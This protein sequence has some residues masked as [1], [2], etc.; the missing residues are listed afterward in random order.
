MANALTE[1]QKKLYAQK[2]DRYES[3]FGRIV[4]S[5]LKGGSLSTMK[6]AFELELR[7]YYTQLALLAKGGR[8][9]TLQDKIDLGILLAKSY[10]FL[11]KFVVDLKDYNSSKSLATDEGAISRGARYSNAWHVY[12][13]YSIPAALADALPALPGQDCLG[14]SLCGCWL[15]WGRVDDVI[16]VYWRLNLIKENCVLCADY[17]VSW[18][19]YEVFISELDSDMLEDDIDFINGD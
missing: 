9:L 17:A 13:R 11:D 19:P 10:D 4:E 8:T 6:K 16:E 14:A 15:E 2:H 5:Y 18:Q 3:E 7:S 1:Q 12:S